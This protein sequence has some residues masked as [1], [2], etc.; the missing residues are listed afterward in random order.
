MPKQRI[1]VN[2]KPVTTHETAQIAGITAR[3][4]PTN[5]LTCLRV[6]RLREFA[7]PLTKQSLWRIE[8][9]DA[10]LPKVSRGSRDVR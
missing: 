10:S 2:E 9:Q 4:S 1:R 7:L 6:G 3:L 5:L 8:K